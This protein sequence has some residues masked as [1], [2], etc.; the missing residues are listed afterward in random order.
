MNTL[1][2]E[3]RTATH[4]H[5]TRLEQRLNLLR[6]GFSLADYDKLLCSFLGYYRPL[7]KTLNALADIN[8]WIPDYPMRIKT[9]LLEQDLLALGHNP[10]ELEQ[11]PECA[12]LPLCSDRS[13]VMGCLYVIE[14]STLGGQIMN[15]H[16]QNSLNLSQGQGLVFFS[17]Y[18]IETMEM[19]KRFGTY[20]TQEGDWDKTRLTE[21]ASQTFVTLERWFEASSPEILT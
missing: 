14:G 11:I 8:V 4:A 12:E 16:F 1:L 9:T 7:E 15:R 17:G 19:W 20:L 5:H 18:G 13:S 10:A 21:S 2:T 3:L 6:A